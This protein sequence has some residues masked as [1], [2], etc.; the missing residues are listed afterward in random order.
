M[1]EEYEKSRFSANILQI[2]NRT[3]AF[4]RCHFRM[5][6]S[7]TEWL[8][9]IFNDTKHRA[10]SLRHMNFLL[11]LL[12]YIFLA[13]FSS[14]TLRSVCY[15]YTLLLFVNFIYYQ[16]SR[17]HISAGVRPWPCVWVLLASMYSVCRWFYYVN[18]QYI[19]F[20]SALYLVFSNKLQRIGL[21]HRRRRRHHPHDLSM[22]CVLGILLVTGCWRRQYEAINL[23]ITD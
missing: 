8:G 13:L 3:Q 17:A 18:I 12:P 20:C 16:F 6:L 2:V 11:S 23:F 10:G 19:L 14:Y 7:D 5:I 15:F 4:E 21:Y 22:F 9:E 1:Q